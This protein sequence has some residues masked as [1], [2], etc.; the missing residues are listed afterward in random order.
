MDGEVFPGG[1]C[2]NEKTRQRETPDGFRK[3]I[4]Q[5]SWRTAPG[6]GPKNLPVGGRLGQG[7][8]FGVLFF[9]VCHTKVQTSES[10][11]LHVMR[12]FCVGVSKHLLRLSFCFSFENHTKRGILENKTHSCMPNSLSKCWCVLSTWR[13]WVSRMQE[14]SMGM[15]GK[16]CL[17]LRQSPHAGPTPKPFKELCRF[18]LSQ[19]PRVRQNEENPQP[20]AISTYLCPSNGSNVGIHELCGG[21]S[22]RFHTWK[23]TACTTSLVGNNPRIQL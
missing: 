20:C 16:G 7:L 21:C 2:T 3:R 22:I 8:P 12:V 9:S 13:V 5:K 18:C 23:Q 4:G 1:N 6:L 11:A 14:A 10:I 19:T 17:Y 15:A